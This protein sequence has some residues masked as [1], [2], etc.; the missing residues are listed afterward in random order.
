MK[1]VLDSFW[2]AVLYCLHP[3]L[4]W[5]SL[6]PL[7][8][9][10]LLAMLLGYFYWD[11][12]MD[13]M[14]NWLES[15]AFA[16]VGWAWLDSVGMG[17]LKATLVPLII[18]FLATPVVVML[19]LLFVNFWM[20]PAVVRMVAR[21]RFADLHSASGGSVLEGVLWALGSTLAALL[22]MAM[23]APLWA[24]PPL[25]LVLP[26]L[27]WGW[28]CYRI[29]AYDALALHAS[30]Q[31]REQILRGHRPQLLLMGLI[32]GYMGVAPS[33]VWVSGT[34]FAAAFVVLIPLAVWIYTLVFV[35][36]SAWFGHYCLAALVQ[37]RQVQG[38]VVVVDEIKE[39]E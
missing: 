31:E 19:V 29:L 32:C 35:F 37:L 22:V 15:N 26:P 20:T 33:V 36:S 11:L 7:V 10:T 12:A 25:V 34:L 9:V 17:R 27:I 6:L 38:T 39:L 8:L 1:Q 28:L 13:A 30:A 16:G 18:I 5:L 14:R 24:I 2:R 23:S 3:R 21:R 4:V